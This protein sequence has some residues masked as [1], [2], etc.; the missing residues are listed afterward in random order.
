MKCCICGAVRNV[1]GYLD[2][3]FINMEKIGSLFDDYVIILCYD[4]SGDD[5]L[6][7]IK[8]YQTQNPRVK[9]YVNKTEV[10]PYRTHRIAFARNMC[11]EMI[12]ANYSS[13]ETFIMMDCDNVC[14]GNIN[15]DVL[16][17]NIYKTGWDALSFNRHNYYD[18]WALSIRPYIFSF[19]HFHPEPYRKMSDYIQNLL[20]N[21]PP[22]NYVKCSSAF[23]GFAIYRTN[24][25]LNC[26][27][28]GRPRLDLIH[29]NYLKRNIQVNR[30]PIVYKESCGAGVNGRFEDCEHRSF[31]MQAINKNGA[32]IRISPEILFN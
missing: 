16:K 8:N 31:H 25:F 27:Y 1:G 11:L 21:T 19:L 24:K 29:P 6:Q 4:N 13:C 10:S 3:I 7:K 2:K 22:D 15:L 26:C 18:I 28:D 20:K 5:T 17:K 12:R 23:N 14:E 32:R 30:S 9:L